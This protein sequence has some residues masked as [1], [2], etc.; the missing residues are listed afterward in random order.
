MKQR[1]RADIEML[2]RETVWEAI[3]DQ[4]DSNEKYVMSQYIEGETIC[5]KGAY[6]NEEKIG[7][8]LTLKIKN[9]I[10]VAMGLM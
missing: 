5:P 8:V 6:L 10:A 7:P 4:F 1:R 3:K 2:V 9:A